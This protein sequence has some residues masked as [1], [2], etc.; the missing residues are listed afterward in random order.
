MVLG[1]RAQM[2]AI[3]TKRPTMEVVLTLGPVI[4]EIG[5]QNA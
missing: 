5:L 4:M 3:C 1:W 2:S